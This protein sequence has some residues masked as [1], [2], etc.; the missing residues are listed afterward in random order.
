[1]G[2]RLSVDAVI[3]KIGKY[4]MKNFSAS[5][6]FII[7][8]IFLFGCEKTSK[9]YYSDGLQKI[10]SKEYSEAIE[11]FSK[12]IEAD[13]TN[14]EAYL[15]RGEYGWREKSMNRSKDLSKYIESV[16]PKLANAL[17]GRGMM[18]RINTEYDKSISDFELAYKL[19]P[20]NVQ[21]YSFKIEALNAK[22]DST[23]ANEFFE[24]LSEN[25]RNKM[26]LLTE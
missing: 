13:S 4:I 2:G 21:P 10:E 7:I 18:R 26:K 14:I 23:I 17:I 8:T 25:I 16:L 1:M 15:A 9:D 5:M 22:G 6:I 3:N 19:T 24:S 12:A 20:E 11:L